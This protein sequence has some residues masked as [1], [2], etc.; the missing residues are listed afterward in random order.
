MTSAQL[1]EVM[2][3]LDEVSKRQDEYNNQY[4]SNSY[5]TRPTDSSVA[6]SFSDAT[7]AQGLLLDDLNNMVAT[8][9]ISVEQL[10]DQVYQNHRHLDDLEQY[11]RSNRL[12]LRGCTNLPEKKASNLNFENFVIKTLNS[13]IKWSQ[14]IANTDIDI[15][16]VLPS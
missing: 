2:K 10:A 3:K 16:H 1:A 5:N 6:A 9:K 7:S 8:L 14:P 12:I 4:L 11:S 15:C 13:R